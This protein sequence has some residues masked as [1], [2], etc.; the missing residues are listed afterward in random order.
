MWAEY[1]HNDIHGFVPLEVA[2]GKSARNSKSLDHRADLA[3]AIQQT[4]LAISSYPSDPSDTVS[5]MQAI[6]QQ[7]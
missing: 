4:I 1:S 3:L 6:L 5:T 7:W 2:Y